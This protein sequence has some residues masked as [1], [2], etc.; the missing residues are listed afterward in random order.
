MGFVHAKQ[1]FW[2]QF[3]NVGAQRETHECIE[4]EVETLPIDEFLNNIAH[5]ST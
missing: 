3:V 5:L 4:I 1:L 2:G